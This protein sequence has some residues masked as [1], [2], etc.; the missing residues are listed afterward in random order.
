MDHKE[1]DVWKEAIVLVEGIYLLTKSLPK[2]EL[3]NLTSQIRRA[4]VS[5]TSNIFP[6]K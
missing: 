4:A 5:I 6:I 1:L 2:E 3:Y